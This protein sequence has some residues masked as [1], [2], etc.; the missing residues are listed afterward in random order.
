MR[1]NKILL[2]A[3]MGCSLVSCDYLDFDESVGK[4]KEEA[5]SSFNN[6]RQLV[7]NVYSYLPQDFG[8]I[9]NALREAATDNAMYVWNTSAV[10]K[11]Y[12]NK[13]APTNTVDDV[14]GNM[15]S[16]I[17]AANSFI[18]NYD[19]DLLER[20]SLNDNY[21]EE[22]EKFRMYPYEVRA[23]RA[24]YYFE[25]AKRYGDVPLVT[26]TLDLDEVNKLT[27]TPF[28]EVMD[29]IA[30]ECS[31][32]ALKLPVDHADFYSETGRATK[33]MALALKSRALL[34]AASKLHNP[35]GDKEL[36]KT[37]ATAA[38]DLISKGWYSLPNIDN[39]P[40]Y[41]KEGA[42]EIFKSSQLIFERRNG[43]SDSFERNN[44]PIG[45]EGGKSGNTPTQNL[46]DAYEMADGTPFDWNNPDHVKY[47]YKKGNSLTRDPRFY[48]TIVYNGATLMDEVVEIYEGGKNGLPQEG[49]TQTGY[50]LRKY[51]N[52]NV[53]LKPE[54]PKKKAHHYILFRYA[55][56]LLNYA[57]AM[58]EWVGEDA[59]PEGF[60]LTAREALNQ[61]RAAANMPK[62]EDMGDA[63]M[64]RLRNERRIELAFEDHRFWDIRRWKIGAVV[65]DVYG[66]QVSKSGDY[67]KIKVR[68]RAWDDK[69]YLYPISKGELNK[70]PGL[71]Q[72]AGW[73]D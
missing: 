73:N 40:I 31:Q 18:E 56:I 10:Y 63:F 33:G 45:Y 4:T 50:Y 29:F 30:E 51:I 19:E 36:W 23:L 27:R 32:V 47:Q 38:H 43:D 41:S 34:Y 1:L 39:D 28:Q 48:K 71:G 52:E 61:V 13:W 2:M 70:N 17:R 64:T 35:T 7:A 24:F 9:G 3:C 16:A 72:N 59:L 49:A 44:L 67:V 14:W 69:M 62:V 6:L 12:D 58:T 68:E 66:V 26:R 65:K 11:I 54:N 57:E 8:A 60:T 21:K 55:E 20:L 5:Y 25:L 53:S 42:N 22:V 15:Y 37:A 46:A